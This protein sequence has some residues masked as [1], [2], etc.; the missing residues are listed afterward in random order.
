MNGVCLSVFVVPLRDAAAMSC[1]YS[2]HLPGG[3]VSVVGKNLE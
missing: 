2:F 1:L 3:I